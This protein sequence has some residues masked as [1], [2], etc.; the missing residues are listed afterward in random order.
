MKVN[1]QAYRSIWPDAD[2]SVVIIDQTQLPWALVEKRLQTP[3]DAVQA[4]REMAVRGAPLI[5]VTAAYGVALAMQRDPSS[6]CL[7][8]TIDQLLASRPTAVNLQWALERMNAALSDAAPEQRARIAKGLADQLA[9]QD[10]ALNIAIGNTGAVLLRAL[11]SQKGETLN[12][13]THCNAGWL[14][15]VDWGTALSPIYKV[16][17]T[18]LPVHV[19]VDETRP[20]NQGA[21]TAWE[22]QNHGVPHT[23]IVDNAGGLLM[24]RGQVDA[25]IVGC[26]RVAANGDVCNKVGSYL[27]ALTAAAHGIPFYVALPSPTF[28]PT[29]ATGAAIPIEER[30]ATEVSHIGDQK[31]VADGTPISNLAFDIAPAELVTAYI[32]DKGV[33]AADQLKA[34]LV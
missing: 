32:T 8:E 24:Q 3:D 34:N 15:T 14:A 6:R 29:L 7:A 27:K 5:G 22:L 18:G 2:G 26:D 21:L 16:H 12:V 33:F 11:Y 31:V 30:S 17:D 19:W 23:Y 20:R 28:D 9:E 10:V 1:T 4:I 13:L 25:V